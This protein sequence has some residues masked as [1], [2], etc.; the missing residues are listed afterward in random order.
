MRIR[1]P[2]VFAPLL[3][4]MTMGSTDCENFEDVVIPATDTTPPMTVDGVWWD[5]EYKVLKA[6]SNTDAIVYHLPAGETSVLAISSAID[7]G[8]VQ[9]VNMHWTERWECCSSGNVN[10]QT[11]YAFSA[12]STYG[13]YQLGEPGDTVS[14]GIWYGREAKKR[15]TVIDC[16]GGKYVKNWKF[17]WH[18]RG[19][20]FQH[21]STIGKTHTILWP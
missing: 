8:G 15:Q 10:C 12:P 3:L 6:S 21:D 7:S 1:Y 9:S 17:E 2:Y 18:T 5:G 19:F 11:L 14:N 13:D 4:S 20:N 16:P